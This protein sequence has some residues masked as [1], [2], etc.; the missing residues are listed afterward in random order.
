MEKSGDSRKFENKG[1]VRIESL[2]KEFR[3]PG[4]RRIRVLER[5]ELEVPRGE[6]L[7]ILGPTGCGKTT[8]LR[9]LAGLE[10]PTAGLVRVDGQTPRPGKAAASVVFQQNSLLPWKRLLSN[11]S[12]PLELMGHSKDSARKKALELL[13]MVGL[14]EFSRAFPYE[15]S[16]GMQQR[17]AIARALASERNILLMDEPFSSLDDKTRRKLQAMMEEIWKEKRVTVLFVT[18]NIEEAIILGS[19]I[20]VMGKGRII[21]DEEIALPRPRDPMSPGFIETFLELRKRFASALG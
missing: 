5:L 10:K 3:G 4:V 17:G 14:A 12:F 13:E 2:E 6:F 11:V 20:V 21:H 9:I 18:H 16:G 15:L 19:R 1:T 7:C 8:L